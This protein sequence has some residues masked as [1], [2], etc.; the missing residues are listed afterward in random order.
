MAP[1][2]AAF[3]VACFRYALLGSVDE[4]PDIIYLANILY[5]NF[6]GNILSMYVCLCIVYETV[7]TLTLNETN[8]GIKL[9][10]NN[11]RYDVCSF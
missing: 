10:V 11:V 4:C 5:F 6:K 3:P 1:L 2:F 7:S 9:S 8:H